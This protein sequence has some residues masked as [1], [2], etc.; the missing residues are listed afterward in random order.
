MHSTQDY[1]G[2]WAL[3]LGYPTRSSIAP[4]PKTLAI[5]VI[6]EELAHI[7]E[8]GSRSAKRADRSTRASVTPIE[9]VKES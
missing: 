7:K 2:N 9:V 5:L 3:E 6:A 1:S 8:S 4:I